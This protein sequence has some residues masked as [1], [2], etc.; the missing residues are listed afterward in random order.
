MSWRILGFSFLFL[1]SL[2]IG[3]GAFA[4]SP[5]SI[6]VTISPENP[7]PR[8]AITVSL[9]SYVDNLD[10]VAITW[11][12]DGRT[13][14]SGVGKKSLSL[15]APAAGVQTLISARV[16]LPSGEINRRIA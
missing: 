3:Q 2:S 7:A 14:L 11:V 9:N 13:V 10:S 15:T 8:E 16:A 6:L 4:S 12:V 5:D 1:F